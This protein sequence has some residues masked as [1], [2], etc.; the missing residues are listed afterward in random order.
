MDTPSGRFEPGKKICL[1]MSD[2]HPETWSPAWS[3]SAILVGLLSFMLDNE[4]TA[5][6]VQ[7]TEK[8]KK[9]LAELSLDFNTS[10]PSFLQL[11]PF[12]GGDAESH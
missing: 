4:I 10:D 12:L 9:R 6:S 5:G 11:F 3:V 1:S 7:T 2:Y 8:E